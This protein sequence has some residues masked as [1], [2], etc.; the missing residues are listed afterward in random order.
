MNLPLNIDPQ[1]M[2]LHLFNLVILGGGLYLLLY[3][4]VKNFIDK[5]LELYA[6]QERET[7]DSLKDAK[8]LKEKYE[9]KLLESEKEIEA[10]K[11]KSEKETVE[12]QREKIVEAENEASL[13]IKK[14]RETALRE[15]DEIMRGISDEVKQV[16]VEAAEKTLLKA[17][18][19]PFEEF[20]NI[21]E[22]SLG[23]E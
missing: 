20:L 17:N 12:L 23:D 21:A 15:H 14:A 16:A 19:D 10:L 5:R 6:T 18:D 2:L 8:R 7:K 9:K 22:R 13:I 11:A 4:P 3:K 1:Q